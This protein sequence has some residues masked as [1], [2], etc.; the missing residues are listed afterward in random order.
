MKNFIFLFY[1]LLCFNS[2]VAGQA[3]PV[4]YFSDEETQL[5]SMMEYY[6]RGT[7]ISGETMYDNNTPKHG[8]LI[9]TDING[10]LLW[11]KKF[12]KDGWNTGIYDADQAP[13]GGI[14]VCGSTNV[15]DS[16]NYT[17][18]PFILKLNACGEKEWCT[19]F[20][21]EGASD[22]GLRV[23]SV[24]DGCVFL[25]GGYGG[26]DSTRISL[27]KLGTDGTFQ[28]LNYYGH[29][30]D[31][32]L[33]GEDGLFMC[34][35][36][37]SGYLITGRANY[38]LPDSSWPCYQRLY[39]I[40]VASSGEL[41]WQLPWDM[42]NFSGMNVSGDAYHSIFDSRGN[43]YTFGRRGECGKGECPCFV[44]TSPDGHELYAGDV[45]HSV[46]GGLLVAGEWMSDSTIAV[47]EGYMYPEQWPWDGQCGVMKIDTLGNLQKEIILLEDEISSPL[48]SFTTSDKKLMYG[49]SF[50]RNNKTKTYLWKLNQQLE[51]DT[52]YTRPFTYDSLCPH[53]IASDTIALDCDIV[54]DVDEPLKHPERSQLKAY[55]NPAT[56]QIT[57]ELPKYLMSEETHGSFTAGHI[58]HQWRQGAVL[59][60]YDSNGVRVLQTSIPSESATMTLDVS[61]WAGGM[62]FIRLVRNG[63]MVGNVK[64]VVRD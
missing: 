60:A 26:W 57:V 35:A 36:P 42:N 62:Y 23:L 20:Y 1:H 47:S 13:D 3:W 38:P 7:L 31:T 50:Y 46:R 29:Q 34:M 45:L 54:V 10:Q 17:Y 21:T 24:N 43:I 40:K 6:D 19:V 5:R 61:Q 2:F 41:E 52:A 25:L 9:K 8:L 39:N 51:P 49:G 44:K 63:K 56:G 4:I 55:P 12:G 48:W 30:Q 37:D 22:W 32:V 28:W 64:V 11:K 33:W 53:A 58:V 15:I 59:E 14:I 16:L 18:D 27:V